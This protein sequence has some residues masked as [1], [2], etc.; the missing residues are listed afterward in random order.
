M[1]EQ[2][3]LVT[4]TATFVLVSPLQHTTL[5]LTNVNATAFYHGDAVGMIHYDEPLEVP[6]GSTETP[7]IPVDW[8]LSSVGYDAVVKALGGMLKLSAEADVAVR[9][10]QYEE[11]IWFAGNGIGAKVRV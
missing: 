3:H 8:S 2:M 7:R 4:S 6:P 1:T 11:K 9:I 5:Y 10:G